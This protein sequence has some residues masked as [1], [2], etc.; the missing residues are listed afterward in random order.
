LFSLSHARSART[1]DVYEATEETV[2]V[3]VR[4]PAGRERHYE[5]LKESVP[6]EVGG[7][8]WELSE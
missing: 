5:L 3:V 6:D 7:G 1:C 2:V 8:E 4:T